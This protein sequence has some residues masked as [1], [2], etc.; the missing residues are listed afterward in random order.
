MDL[1]NTFTFD[2]IFTILSLPVYA[3]FF[4]LSR[5]SIEFRTEFY[6]MIEKST[7]TN[8]RDQ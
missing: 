6:K 2:P 7:K 3:P 1:R 8:Y 5:N 4:N